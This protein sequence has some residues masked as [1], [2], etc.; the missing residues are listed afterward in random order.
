MLLAEIKEV[1]KASPAIQI[2]RR[3]WN[4]SRKRLQFNSRVHRVS[5]RVSDSTPSRLKETLGTFA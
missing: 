1:I 5:C 2:Q 3:A 4:V